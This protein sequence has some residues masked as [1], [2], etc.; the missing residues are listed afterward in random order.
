MYFSSTG[1]FCTYQV[2]RIEVYVLSISVCP[3][4]LLFFLLFFCLY[5]ILWD[6]LLGLEFGL[7]ITAPEI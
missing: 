3:L 2:F 1:D 5:Y 6:E 4:G 7:P